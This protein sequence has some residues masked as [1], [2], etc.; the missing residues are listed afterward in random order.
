MNQVARVGA[1]ALVGFSV[2]GCVVPAARY[3]EARSAIPGGARGSP[4]H[5]GAPDRGEP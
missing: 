2:V 3:E 5:P 4:S 1:L